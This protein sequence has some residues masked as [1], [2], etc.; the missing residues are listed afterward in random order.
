MMAF[1]KCLAAGVAAAFLVL[2]AGLL[3]ALAG[4]AW[5]FHDVSQS[6]SGGLGA[7]SFGASEWAFPLAVA[8][9]IAG[10][11]WQYRRIRRAA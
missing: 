4:V 6:G 11:T 2:A 5:M 9:F 1:V 7:V 8:A 3:A 10:F